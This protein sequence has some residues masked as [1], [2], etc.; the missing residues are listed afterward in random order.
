LTPDDL[1]RTH[2]GSRCLV[3]VL[4]CIPAIATTLALIIAIL[5]GVAPAAQVAYPLPQPAPVGP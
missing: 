5:N 4:A 3:Y 2:S 1:R